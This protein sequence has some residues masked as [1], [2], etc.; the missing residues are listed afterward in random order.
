MENKSGIRHRAPGAQ[1]GR[2]VALLVP[3]KCLMPNAA[4]NANERKS[5]RCEGRDQAFAAAV[6]L[7]AFPVVAL[8]VVAFAGPAL[9][10]AFS[11]SCS[12][13]RF[14]AAVFL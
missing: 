4:V 8:P 6:P 13:L 9:S 1:A 12:R 10:A 2:L 3:A 14:R 7:P 5:A 11:R